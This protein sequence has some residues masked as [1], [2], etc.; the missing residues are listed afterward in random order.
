VFAGGPFDWLTPY[1]V[2]VACGLAAGYVLLGAGWL[3]WKTE[4]ALHGDARRWAAIAGVLTALFLAAVSLATLFLQPQLAA[5]WGVANGAVD[6]SRFLPMAPI[7]LLGLAGLGLAAFGLKRASHVL[8]FVGGILVFL[9]GY[10]GLA[11]GFMP[12]VAPYVLTFR[13]AAAADNAL[14][15]MLGG[16]VLLAPAIVGYTVW[17]YW[18]FR[19]KV[20]ADAGYH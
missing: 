1:S 14:A 15:L 4:D 20:D 18:V 17:V 11:A 9:S 10:L 2:L 13:Q 3:M 12:Y 8:P 16:A 7:P 5:R 19:G 6:W